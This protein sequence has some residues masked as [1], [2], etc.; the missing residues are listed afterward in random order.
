MAREGRRRWLVAVHRAHDPDHGS[1]R[2]QQRECQ[3]EGPK[4]HNP[5]SIH[6]GLQFDA[7]QSS[8]ESASP[9]FPIVM[10]AVGVRANSKYDNPDGHET[11]THE[12]F[13][14]SVLLVLN[15]GPLAPLRLSALV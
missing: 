14:H 10:R 11:Y 1:C 12:Q 15:T 8:A 4:P 3:C 2:D 7:S 5:S 13:P 9:V 6:A